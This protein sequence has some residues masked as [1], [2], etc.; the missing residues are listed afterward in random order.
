MSVKPQSITELAECW[1]ELTPM[2]Q[3]LLI[4]RAQSLAAYNKMKMQRPGAEP[5]ESEDITVQS[6]VFQ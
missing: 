5:A 4:Q 2:Q 6:D 1:D 3:Q